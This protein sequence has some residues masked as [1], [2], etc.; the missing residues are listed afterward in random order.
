[1][2]NLAD[3]M[4]SDQLLGG[5]HL[6]GQL[7]KHDPVLHTHGR[8]DQ[9][10]ELLISAGIVISEAIPGL[11]TGITVPKDSAQILAQLVKLQRTA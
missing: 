2:S 3:V 10:P 11:N 5:V 6:H 1:M 9:R 7:V 8:N 4:S